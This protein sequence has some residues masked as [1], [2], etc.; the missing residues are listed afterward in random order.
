MK[1]ETRDSHLLSSVPRE[2]FSIHSKFLTNWYVKHMKRVSC[3]YAILEMKKFW[4]TIEATTYLLDLSVTSMTAHDR[5]R[6][7]VVVLV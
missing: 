7:L 4:C 6:H 1:G 5:R 3:W 2:I